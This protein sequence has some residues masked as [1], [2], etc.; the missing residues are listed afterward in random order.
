MDIY[1]SMKNGKDYPFDLEWM[2]CLLVGLPD[3]LGLT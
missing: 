3:T 1:F 2:M